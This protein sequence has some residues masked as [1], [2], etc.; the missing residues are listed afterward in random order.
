M[1][2]VKV[3]KV[4]ASPPRIGVVKLTLPDSGRIDAVLGGR[5][6]QPGAVLSQR[7]LT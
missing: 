7:I 4:S 6:Q 3:T 1:R 5:G 2:H